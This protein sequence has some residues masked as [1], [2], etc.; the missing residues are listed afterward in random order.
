MLTNEQIADIEKQAAFNGGRCTNCQQTIKVYRYK[1]NKAHS[2][3]IKAMANEVRASGV[4]DVDISTIGLAYSIR[5]Q[6]TKLRQHGLIARIKNAEGAQIPRR[7]LVTKKG[8]AFV[9]GDKVP[10]KVVIYANQVLGHEGDMVNI[11]DVLGEK[12]DPIAP[13]YEETPVSEPE[14]R[15]YKD[16]KKH[17]RY[18]IVDAVFKGR[19][20]K[21]LFK[22]SRSYQLQIKRLQIGNPVEIVSIDGKPNKKKYPDI[23]AFQKDWKVL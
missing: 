4:N 16:L 3:F 5:S 11:Y 18:S 6:V 9:N 23:A 17:F 13:L 2:Q 10:S 7:W 8:W 12:F 19:D 22:V 20:Y 21:G 14:A 15:I 1:L